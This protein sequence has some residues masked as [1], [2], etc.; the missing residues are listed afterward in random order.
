MVGSTG[1][2]LV[3]T[4]EPTVGDT[5]NQNYFIRTEDCADRLQRYTTW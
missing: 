1:S 2:F 5:N 3:L 4:N